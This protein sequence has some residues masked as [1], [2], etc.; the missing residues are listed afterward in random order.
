[1]GST[2]EM[3]TQTITTFSS[4]THDTG[5]ISEGI[6]TI[7]EADHVESVLSTCEV[8]MKSDISMLSRHLI[9]EDAGVTTLTISKEIIG[10]P[11]INTGEIM[12]QTITTFSSETHD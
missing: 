6:Q 12:T 1:M 2:G 10:G 3:G 9:E 8:E 4:E 5:D 11:E 7:C